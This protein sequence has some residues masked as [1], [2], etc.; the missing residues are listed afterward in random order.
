M[1]ALVRARSI[2]FEDVWLKWP[3]TALQIAGCALLAL[4]IGPS[5][6]AYP[7]M[8][9]G[10]ALWLAHGIRT[11]DWPLSALYVAFEITNLI[12]IARWLLP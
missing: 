9:A 1:S 12:G 3:G 10:A 2:R 5:P 8:T 4:R 6:F 11:R 7:L